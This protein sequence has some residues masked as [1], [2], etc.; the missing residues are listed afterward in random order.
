[1]TMERPL[2]ENDILNEK[3]T[4]PYYRPASNRW[5]VQIYRN[6]K[7]SAQFYSRYLMEQT[8]G[9]YLDSDECVDHIDENKLNDSIDNLQILTNA[10]NVSKSSS[11]RPKTQLLDLVCETCNKDFQRHKS[12]IRHTKSG[13]YCSK[14]CSGIGRR[15]NGR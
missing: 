8:L 6:G 4:G 3:V 11:N 7:R 13:P 1:M 15:E 14:E 2:F 5:I 9:R 12:M 10:E